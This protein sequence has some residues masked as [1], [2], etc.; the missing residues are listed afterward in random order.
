M[1]KIGID[2]VQRIAALA[3]I[4]LSPEEAA[5]MAV[6]LG[7]IVAFVEQLQSVN[8]NGIIPTSQVTGLE[9]IWRADIV[10]ASKL[11]REQLLANAPAQSHGY[12]KVRRVL[13]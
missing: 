11:S 5:N 10:A 7:Q 1:S 9:D 4:A 8:T 13:G 3:H 2:E 12:I 6:E